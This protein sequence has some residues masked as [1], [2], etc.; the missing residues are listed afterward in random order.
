[1]THVGALRAR[2]YAGR[3]AERARLLDDASQ[4]EAVQLELLNREWARTLRDV[5]YYAQLRAERS[6][7]EV[8]S[9]L[10]E[11][12]ASVPIARREDVQ[13]NLAAMTSRGR[14]PE[15]LRITGGSTAAPV[16]LPAWRSESAA[17][18]YEFWVARGWYGV[19]PDSRLFL[20]WGH[21]HLLGSGWRGWLRARRQA[22]SDRALGYHRFSAYDLRP[23]AMERAARELLR[24]RPD[25]V[26]GYSTAL[27][28]FARA[29]AARREA[30]RRCGL[31][32]V[33]ATAESFPASDSRE[34]LADLFDCP[35]AMEYGAVE[36]GPIAHSRPAGDFLVFWHSH[37]VEGVGEGV[38]RRVVLTS[39]YP[40][41][42]P[43]VRYEIGDEIELAAEQGGATSIAAFQ[44]VVGRCNDY[45][46]LPDG[47]LVH[48]EAFSH[49]VRPCATVRG[50]Q[51][52][53]SGSELRLRYTA[54]RPLD[55]HEIADIQERLGRIHAE[56]GKIAFE[57]VASL[58]QTIAGKTRMVVRTGAQP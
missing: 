53:Q 23:E 19:R 25:Y 12:A 47:T 11:F 56:L 29:N 42:F 38:R 34:R 58:D 54:D 26:L 41:A 52:A 18:R 36:T 9:S 14:R 40:R 1:M 32:L 3:I 4:R 7:P 16:Q 35:V 20:L 37:L 27:D 22:L 44:R 2:R 30:L 10:E 55:A 51:V 13:R 50:Y 49:A 57:R 24:F 43:L 8:F 39:L 48:S 17:T 21:S 15:W 45:A 28:L 31:R 33:V 46:A 5:P 6:L